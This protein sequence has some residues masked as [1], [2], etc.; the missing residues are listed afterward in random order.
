MIQVFKG[1]RY[2]VERL[3]YNHKVLGSVLGLKKKLNAGC[4]VSQ[5]L[6]SQSLLL[7]SCVFFTGYLALITFALVSRSLFI[8]LS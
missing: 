8:Q 2:V 6:I 5:C 7:L 3:P 1:W 4:V